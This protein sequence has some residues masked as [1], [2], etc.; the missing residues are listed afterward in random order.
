[1][2]KKNKQRKTA[3]KVQRRERRKDRKQYNVF[4]WKTELFKLKQQLR[5]FGLEVREITGDGNCLFRAISDQMTGSENMHSE[6]RNLACEFMSNNSEDFAP[7]VEDD[8]TFESYISS[9]KNT[10]T[11]GGN[12]ELQALS[13]V[14]EVNI[15]IHMVDRPIWE[16]KNNNAWRFIHL[17]YH[18][19]DHYNSV[20]LKGDNSTEPS[21]AIPENLKLVQTKEEADQTAWSDALEYAGI[22]TQEPDSKLL[23]H[24]LKENFQEAPSMELLNTFAGKLVDDLAKAKKAGIEIEEEKEAPSKAPSKAP[25][26]FRPR[27]LPKNNQKCWCNSGKKY[28]KCCKAMDSFREPEPEKVVT[29]LGS[30]R[31]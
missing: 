8:Q 16:I 13:L 17:S 5:P 22:L 2:A 12:M 23:K 1:M 26:G 21:K 24:L 7:F 27:V 3:N 15:K 20:R 25:A 19:G 9:M 30:L 31:I 29:E 6:Y 10:S 18:D 11:W 28:N 4:E 14:L